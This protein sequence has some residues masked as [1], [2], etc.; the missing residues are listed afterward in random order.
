SGGDDGGEK[1]GPVIAADDGNAAE[2]NEG[3]SDSRDPGNRRRRA[4]RRS[5][6]LHCGLGRQCRR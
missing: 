3:V 6:L 5:R 4:G 2:V 1:E